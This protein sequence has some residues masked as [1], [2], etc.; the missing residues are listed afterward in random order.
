M[1][2]TVMTLLCA[3]TLAGGDAVAVGS[4][5]GLPIAGYKKGF[6]IHSA[7]RQFKLHIGGLVQ[8]R[9]HLMVS[10]DDLGNSKDQA[11]SIPRA[12]FKLSGNLFSDRLKYSFQPDFGKGQVGLK[13]IY[14]DYR[15]IDEW[16]HLRVGQFK[17]PFSRQQM[18][19]ATSQEHIDAAITD[20]AF[21][22]GRDIGIMFHND[23]GKS[24]KF[25]WAF[26]L[27]NGS[28]IST[29]LE[30]D[31]EVDRTTGEGTITSGKLLNVP[32]HFEPML[33]ARV[34]YNYGDVKGYAEGDLDGGPLR[35]A[36]GLST[37]AT[38]DQD[39]SNDSHVRGELDY[40][41]KVL[42]FAATGAVFVSSLQSG[43]T[44]KKQDLEAYGFYCQ[45]SYLVADMVQPIFRYA[46]VDDRKDDTTTHTVGGGLAF[47]FFGHQFKAQVDVVGITVETPGQSAT[48]M[49]LRA[50]LQGAF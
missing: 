16:L 4:D 38:F 24:Q 25:E 46:I 49:R 14:L 28:G 39:N 8:V 48:D 3:A 9:Y 37:Q 6:F 31:V 27:F 36:V 17:R 22:A 2:V 26:G 10:A 42:G 47:Y 50:Q 20:K 45:F 11:F 32:D 7:D 1:T 15:F 13:D 43:K 35:M 44:Y 40:V 41:V 23:F 19:S 34:G 33:V 30:G 12:R 21:G 18:T 29:R 5:D